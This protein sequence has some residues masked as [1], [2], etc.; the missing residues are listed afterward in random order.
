MFSLLGDGWWGGFGYL[1]E[2][3]PCFHSFHSG[4][5]L[6]CDISSFLTVFTRV[7]V[8]T[9]TG[10]DGVFW[11]SHRVFLLFSL[12]SLGMGWYV[13]LRYGSE[14][15]QCIH[16]SLVFSLFHCY[17]SAAVF[18]GGLR[19]KDTKRKDVFTDL[20]FNYLVVVK[21]NK[22][23]PL[24]EVLIIYVQPMIVIPKLFVVH[25]ISNNFHYTRV[26]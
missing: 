14:C 1:S 6:V 21:T 13:G 12:F 2:C 17:L 19:K 18:C 23:H 7:L 9:Q 3:F 10:V 25:T 20:T 11:V 26:Y 24:F 22:F 4:I 5:W 8:I 16:C 15:F